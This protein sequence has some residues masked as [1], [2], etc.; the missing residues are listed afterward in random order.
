[1]QTQINE[2][3]ALKECELKKVGRWH[4]LVDKRDG[5]VIYC[6]IRTPGK[7]HA[8]EEFCYFMKYGIV[9]DTFVPFSAN[10]E[11]KKFNRGR[12]TR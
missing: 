3:P 6:P 4:Y 8:Y 12:Y 1:M 10:L 5:K 2:F 9:I 11:F 7:K